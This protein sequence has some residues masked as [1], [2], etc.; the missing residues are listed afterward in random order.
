MPRDELERVVLTE[1]AVV[2]KGT[3]PARAVSPKL[4]RFDVLCNHGLVP[5]EES[6]FLD[7]WRQLYVSKVR[8][9][10]SVLMLHVHYT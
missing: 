3:V 4:A 8:T 9:Q 7:V 5:V 6:R 2:R 1:T 10:A